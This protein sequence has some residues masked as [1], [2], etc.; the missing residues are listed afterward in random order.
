MRPT[1]ENI[2]LSI[3]TQA[4]EH[5]YRDFRLYGV[6]ISGEGNGTAQCTIFLNQQ[7]IDTWHFALLGPRLRHSHRVL[8]LPNNM[9]TC[10]LE[11]VRSGQVRGI[12]I[13]R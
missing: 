6:A 7:Y 11:L 13:T 5:K 3:L 1:T 10:Q 4:F 8:R 2:S 9:L 12:P